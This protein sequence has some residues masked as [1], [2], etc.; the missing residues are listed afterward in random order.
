[1][2]INPRA[3]WILNYRGFANARKRQ[4]DRAL[5]DFDEEAKRAPDMKAFLLTVRASTLALAGR[6]DQAAAAYDEAR[7]ANDAYMPRA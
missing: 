5:A 1:M 4:W 3:S 6:Y 2:R 7:K